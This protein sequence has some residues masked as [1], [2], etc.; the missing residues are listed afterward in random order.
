VWSL[1][2][3]DKH[4]TLIYHSDY[5]KSYTSEAPST[6]RQARSAGL[7]LLPGVSRNVQSGGGGGGGTAQ[8][9]SKAGG[10]ASNSRLP[11]DEEGKLVYGVVFSLRNMVRKLNGPQETFNSY[12]TQAYTLSHYQLPT[13]YT[14]VLISDPVS[15]PGLNSSG[16]G[17]GA[18]GSG[19]SSLLQIASGPWQEW[20]VRNP[21]VALERS[22]EERKRGIDSEGFR[23]ATER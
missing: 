20:V 21:A 13:G 11:L 6:S 12:T 15:R 3:W 14:L 2:I 1:W 10:G 19:R 9:E 16:A 23:L 18:G 4:C 22:G 7:T 5:A 17:A 8:T